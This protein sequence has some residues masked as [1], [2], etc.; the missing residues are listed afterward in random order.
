MTN[1]PIVTLLSHADEVVISGFISICEM[2]G[3]YSHLVVNSVKTPLHSPEEL[4]G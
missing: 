1:L 2:L 4:R 3:V